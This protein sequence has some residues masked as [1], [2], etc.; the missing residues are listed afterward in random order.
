MRVSASRER[1]SGKEFNPFSVCPWGAKLEK[2]FSVAILDKVP[3]R[4]WDIRATQDAAVEN[5]HYLLIA[6]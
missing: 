6:L 5:N 3:T 4:M 2:Q 1:G